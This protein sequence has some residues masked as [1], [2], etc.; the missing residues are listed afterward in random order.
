[1]EWLG[2]AGATAAYRIAPGLGDTLVRFRVTRLRGSGAVELDFAGTAPWLK[3]PGTLTLRGLVDTISLLQHPPREPGTYSAAVRAS[4]KGVRG[5]LL[6]L[7]STVVIPATTQAAPV[8]AATHLPAGGL[9]R[10]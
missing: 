10:V 9:Q 4:A 5:P 3:A 7:V 8:R 2:Q 6:S 1:M